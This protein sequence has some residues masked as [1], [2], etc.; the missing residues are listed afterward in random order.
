MIDMRI[1]GENKTIRFK[2]LKISYRLDCVKE[3]CDKT[4]MRKYGGG[5]TYQGNPVVEASSLNFASD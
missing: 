1:Y 2:H 4:L 5:S 3:L